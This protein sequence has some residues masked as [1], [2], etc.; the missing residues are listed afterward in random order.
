MPDEAASPIDT[1]TEA[2]AQ[3]GMK[4]PMP[5]RTAFVSAH[6]LSTGSNAGCILVLEQGRL[7]ER[8]SHE[9]LDGGK[10]PVHPLYTGNAMGT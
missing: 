3:E 9:Q 10:R 8:G 4:R 2:L 1:R 5:G 7:I 6:R